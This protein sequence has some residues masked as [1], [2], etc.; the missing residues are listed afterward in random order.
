MGLVNRVLPDSVF[1]SFVD[2]YAQRIRENAPLTI[3]AVKAVTLDIDRDPADRDLKR[4]ASMV[5]ACFDSLRPEQVQAGATIEVSGRPID[6]R[7]L[8]DGIAWFDFT[9][10]CETARAA[11]DY[12]E[13]G[14]RFHT[15]L[16]SDVPLMDGHA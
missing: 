16:L 13:L 5:Q 7:V 15:V 12:I 10:V 2:D 11:A 8:A 3:A 4:L 6:V 9:A 1:D 14:Q